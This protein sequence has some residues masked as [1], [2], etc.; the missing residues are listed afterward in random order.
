M[1]S[2]TCAGGR[3]SD[4]SAESGCSYEFIS[5]NLEIY[6]LP[7]LIELRSMKTF[8]SSTFRTAKTGKGLSFQSY[9][10]SV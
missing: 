8:M 4:A 2:H 7:L 10:Q 5:V 9:C 1:I 6:E 3:E